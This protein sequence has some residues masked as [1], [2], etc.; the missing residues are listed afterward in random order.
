MKYIYYTLCL[1]AAHTF[2]NAQETISFVAY[3]GFTLGTL[4]EQNGWE[5]TE[6]RNGFLTNQIVTDENASHGTYSFKN[7]DQSEYDPQWMVI[8][9]G[10]KA[11]EKGAGW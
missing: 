2:T 4:N 3:E 9:G 10:S 6:G 11:F 8:F 7:G 5:V 1:L